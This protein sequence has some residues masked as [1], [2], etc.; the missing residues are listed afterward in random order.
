LTATVPIPGSFDTSSN[1]SPGNQKDTNNQ[2]GTTPKQPKSPTTPTN[3]SQ[4]T[5]NATSPAAARGL[6]FINYRPSPEPAFAGGDPPPLLAV[7][8]SDSNAVSPAA[9]PAKK[10]EPPGGTP[11]DGKGQGTSSTNTNTVNTTAST[12][13]GGQVTWPYP[14]TNILIP[15]PASD[16]LIPQEHF[17]YQIVY[18]PDLTQKY[19]LRIHGGHG[20]LRA[21]ENLVNGWMHTGP[22]PFYMHNSTSAE[23]VT[24]ALQG[25]GSLI[26]SIAQG[27]TS[28]LNPAGAAAKA[29]GASTP[30]TSGQGDIKDYAILYVYEP[31]TD[32]NGN[33]TWSMCLNGGKPVKFLRDVRGVV[34]ASED[35]GSPAL[36]DDAQF[37]KQVSD[38]ITNHFKTDY[39]FDQLVVHSPTLN[40]G[41]QAIDIAANVTRADNKPIIQNELNS[42]AGKV[43]G[44][45]FTNVT[46][47]Q[48]VNIAETNI[49]VTLTFP[50]PPP[51]KSQ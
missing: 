27:V 10:S 47:V 7:A 23:T 13:N 16:G 9:P 2:T 22:G 17:T 38:D 39:V 14:G 24:A 35:R 11:P 6:L 20:E 40:P 48:M 43:Q 51:I 50:G 3:A 8:D 45:V 41:G 37:D 44:E 46:T 34:A 36:G 42:L 30:K 1:N 49:S 29:A 19:G 5:A 32:T 31:R 4:Q 28:G 18:L 26:Q 12:P 21:T 33:V 15:D 25:T